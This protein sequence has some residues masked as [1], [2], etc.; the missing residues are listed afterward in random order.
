MI[1]SFC[2]QEYSNDNFEFIWVEFYSDV[3]PDLKKRIQS[4]GNAKT[5]CLGN[6]KS[7][8]WHLGHC[9]NAGIDASKGHVLVIA[10]GDVIA[11]ANLL[12]V[13]EREHRLTDELVLYFRRWDESAAKHSQSRSYDIEY[14]QEVCTLNN[15]TNY[16]GC[17]SIKKRH[18]LEVN[19]YERSP[20][21]AGSGIN[22]MELY[23]RFRNRGYAIKWHP[24]LKIFHPSHPSTGGYATDKDRM[25]RLRALYPWLNP[26]AGIEQSW[27][28]KCREMDLTFKAGEKEV[29]AYLRTMPVIGSSENTKTDRPRS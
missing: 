10:D 16:A 24:S 20:V 4:F 18:M 23:T 29:E 17:F 2:G 28:L 25:Q 22:G 21:F 5:I 14:L 13:I 26:Y 19:G 6:D 15:P 7:T 27:V 11:P 8:K 3:A 1:D 9:L 12:T